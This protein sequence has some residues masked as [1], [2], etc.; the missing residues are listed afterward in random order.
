MFTHTYKINYMQT[1]DMEFRIQIKHTLKQIKLF[2]SEIFE[3]K[4]NC[5][6]TPN[7]KEEL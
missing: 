2:P 3:D 5:E 4:F 6:K 1:N 7:I